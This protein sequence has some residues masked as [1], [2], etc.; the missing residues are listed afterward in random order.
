MEQRLKS[1]YLDHDLLT[2]KLL[3]KVPI[4][5][6][7]YPHHYHIRMRISIINNTTRNSAIQYFFHLSDNSTQVTSNQLV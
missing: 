5:K 2:R 7:Q 4:L 6:K 3:R 1:D